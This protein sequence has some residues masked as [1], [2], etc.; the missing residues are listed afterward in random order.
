[1]TQ[2][3]ELL[4]RSSLAPLSRSPESTAACLEH[5]LTLVL[6]CALGANDGAII[7]PSATAR[8]CAVPSG[9]REASHNSLV[10]A[11]KVDH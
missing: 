7:I 2:L 11:N 6:S 8:V 3:L 10:A 4:Q 9:G 5:V 1:M